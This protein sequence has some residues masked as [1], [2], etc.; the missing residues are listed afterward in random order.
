VP[1]N[2]PGDAGASHGKSAQHAPQAPGS[3]SDS[4]E[5]ESDSA[6][7]PTPSL[8]GLCTAYQAGATSNPGKAIDNPAFSVLVAAAGG[9]DKVADYCDE[10]IGP[11]PTHPAGPPTD[12]IPSH[13][14]GAPDVS[15]PAPSHS[16]P[17]H[18]TGRP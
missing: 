1:S 14:T 3:E 7:T 6:G 11:R 12:V 10:L 15:H 2:D 4:G 5:P 18:P 9:T 13:P 8:Q 17:S 16:T